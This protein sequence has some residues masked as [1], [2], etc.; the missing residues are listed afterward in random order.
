MAT[1]LKEIVLRLVQALA[2]EDGKKTQAELSKQFP[3]TPIKDI[4]AA[5][6]QGDKTAI[7]RIGE[8][9]FFRQLQ[10]QQKE[11][12]KLTA[13]FEAIHLAKEEEQ[14]EEDL[15]EGVFMGSC[16]CAS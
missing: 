5:L 3:S 7:K 12:L 2:E 1:L 10:E 6:E 11:G 8:Q 4:K 13:S 9:E 15:T 14:K 16:L